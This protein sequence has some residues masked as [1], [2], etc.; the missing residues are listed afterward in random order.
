MVIYIVDLP[1]R[2]SKQKSTGRLFSNDDIHV[3]FHTQ[4]NWLVYS[5]ISKKRVK[6]EIRTYRN[7]L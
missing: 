6:E 5:E 2:E 4:R 1:S 7:F 3:I